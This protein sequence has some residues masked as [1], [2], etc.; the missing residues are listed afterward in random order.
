MDVH[1]LDT[2]EAQFDVP[3]DEAGVTWAGRRTRETC[4][5]AKTPTGT[6][7]NMSPSRVHVTMGDG[8]HPA[9]AATTPS[10]LKDFNCQILPGISFTPLHLD[11]CFHRFDNYYLL[12]ILLPTI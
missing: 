11:F 12:Y 6:C 3:K 7:P 8:A 1:R 5:S 10:S 9:G 4:G 2:E